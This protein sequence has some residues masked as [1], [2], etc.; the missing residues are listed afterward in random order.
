ML[1]NAF[2]KKYKRTLVK[3]CCFKFIDVADIMFSL[4]CK[5]WKL[6]KI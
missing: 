2:Y 3:S 4:F 5:P 6:F 1:V